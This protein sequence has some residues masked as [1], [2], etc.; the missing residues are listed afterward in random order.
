MKNSF[1]YFK[2]TFFAIF[3]LV[4]TTTCSKKSSDN[5]T[6]ATSGGGG[7]SGEAKPTPPDLSNRTSTNR[8]SGSG[9]P[10]SVPVQVVT[11]SGSS[12]TVENQQQQRLNGGSTTGLDNLL[13]LGAGQLRM[14][15]DTVRSWFGWYLAD[16]TVNG[17][18][19]TS[20]QIAD[21]GYKTAIMFNCDASGYYWQYKFKDKIWTWGT[22]GIDDSTKYIAF[23]FDS[24]ALRTPNRIWEIVKAS[25]TRMVVSGIYDFNND[26][27]PDK[28]TM[29]WNAYHLSKDKFSGQAQLDNSASILLGNWIFE[30]DSS[31]LAISSDGRWRVGANPAYGDPGYSYGNWAVESV[32]G[33][34]NQFLIYASSYDADSAGLNPQLVTETYRAT[35]SKFQQ[36]VQMEMKLENTSD[37][38]DIESVGTIFILFKQ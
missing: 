2:F 6:P 25:S 35:V 11:P 38:A 21:N 22:W 4:L 17:K 12:V 5:P 24:S 27:E 34:S 26:R 36:I 29:G 32:A 31:T 7:T 33:T 14:Q 15:Q 19:F 10:L 13:G 3:L 9:I 37:P 18:S 30:K 28:V 16:M 8:E 1:V 23:D 20:Q